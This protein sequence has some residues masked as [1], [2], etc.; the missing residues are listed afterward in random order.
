MVRIID[1]HVHSSDRLRSDRLRPYAELNGLRYDLAELLDLME[2]NDVER[3]LLLS[4]PMGRGEPLPNSKVVKI[5]ERSRGKLFPVFTVEPEEKAVKQA[6]KEAKASAGEVK[7]F[8]IWL[9]YRKVFASDQVFDPLYDFSEEKGS[10]CSSTQGIPRPATEA[11]RM[12]TPLPW[13]SS[14]T[15]ARA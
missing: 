11:W 6:I 3:G 15:S 12:R 7:A 13:T 5:C 10:R 14:R 9:G 2:E 8:K 4:P 1:A